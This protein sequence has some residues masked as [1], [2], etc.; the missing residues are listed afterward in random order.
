MDASNVGQDLQRRLGALFTYSEHGDYRRIRT[1]YLHPDGDN[2]DLFC[3]ADGDTLT[4]SDLVETAGWLRMQSAALRRSPKQTRLIEDTCV[5]HGIEFYRGMLQARCRPGDE[6]AQVVTR[7][8][9][10]AL[11]VS[12]LWFTFRTQAVES[13]TDEVADFLTEHELGFERAEKLVGRSG[14][15]WTV[16]FHVRTERRSS[17]VQVLSTGNRA[18]AHRVSEHVLAAWH[19][20]NHLVAGPEALTFVSLFDDTA[21]IW[22]DEDFRLVE[23]LSTVARWSRPDE[24][25]AVLS[26]AA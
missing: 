4:V 8:A 12:D 9:Q 3:K 1:P 24:F 11:R 17:L 2:I 14:R 6:L 7:V 25:A 19:D 10:A 13:I 20:L 21:D 16:D 18:A 26:D 15:G 23:P 5:T 22:A